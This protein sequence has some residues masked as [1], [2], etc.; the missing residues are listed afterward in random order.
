MR[1]A[2][3]GLR[4]AFDLAP[5]GLAQFDC[6]GR[7]LLVNDRLCEI[8]DCT[9]EFAI[10]R[11]FQELTFPDDL[12]HCLELTR[13]LAAGEIPRYTLEKRFVRPN[14]AIVWARITVSAARHADGSVDFF[15]GAAEDITQQVMATAA[16]RQTEERLRVA[17]DAS[18]IGTFR[19]D[20]SRHALEWAD[21]LGR[22]FG[23]DDS[24]TLD[25]FFELIHPDDRAQVMASYA[26]SLERGVDFEEDFR[27]IWPDG[28]IHWVHDRGR[29][30]L[31]EDGL[32]RFIVGAITD[33]SHH[34]RMA[35]V[36][37]HREAQFRTLAN[38]IPQ[39]AW[40]ADADGGR[41]WFN[42]RWYEYTGMTPEE[43]TGLGWIRAVESEQEAEAVLA[44]QRAAFSMG[45]SWQ[46]T[47]RLRGRNGEV[48]SFLSQ[49]MP[50]RT[51]DA[52]ITQ[53]FG[54]NTDIT[55]RLN[56]ERELEDA[57]GRERVARADAEHAVEVRDQ[58]LGF[59]A[60]DLRNPLQGITFAAQVLLDLSHSEEQRRRQL[61]LI[62]RCARDIE[63]LIS[64]LL[65][66]SNM[67]AGTFAV[68]REPTDVAAVLR[69]VARAHGEQARTRGLVLTAEV[70]PDLRPVSGDAQRLA[71]AMTNIV[72]NALKF[73]P[74]GGSVRISA[75]QSAEHLQLIV[76]DT[77]SG[78]AAE[79]L[80]HIFDR[81]WQASRTRGGA[82]LGLAIVKGIVASHDGDISVESVP[83]KGTTFCVQLP[84]MA[85]QSI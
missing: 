17:L 14:G 84:S 34:K 66:V 8:L 6:A 42:D 69:E 15:I 80:P 75:T 36:I 60:H 85:A 10:G 59:V 29:T 40:I 52:A 19:F 73:T 50:V 1:D 28:S 5:I 74:G 44:S 4:A 65:D 3:A 82:G 55:D 12:A 81:F 25:Q 26:R 46:G 21:G 58:I 37:S 11:T 45:R 30:E 32:P 39:L 18:M 76:Q 9:P 83:N 63:R 49:A 33:I 23:R 35:D 47:V 51:A 2:K 27:V 56:A 64:D 67:E 61:E 13:Q 22:V 20:L 48:R 43:M 68:R 7:F 24:V 78:I 77:G 79:N 38:T 53:W 72:S 54:T 71:Q 70:A 41:S 57:L 62:T 31:D 16:L